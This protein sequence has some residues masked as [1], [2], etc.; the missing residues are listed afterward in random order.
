MKLFDAHTHLNIEEYDEAE[1]LDRLRTIEESGYMGIVIDAG[2]SPANSVQ[3]VRN[4]AERSWCYA[5]V[6]IH[7]HHASEVTDA[8][9]EMVRRLAVCNRLAGTVSSQSVPDPYDADDPARLGGKVVAIG[10]VGLDF[11]FEPYSEED[12]IRIFR[13]QIRI[14]NEL[15]L[16]LMIHT[17]DADRLTFDIL[18][19]EGA[20]SDERCSW[21]PQ[22]PIQ[23][24]GSDEVTNGRDARVQLHCYSGSAELAKEYL[25][26]GASFS[27]GGPITFKNSRKPV[28]VVQRIPL[29]CIMSETDAP[30][31]APEPL[32]GRP[33]RTEYIIHMV[34]RM[35]V[36]KNAGFEETAAMLYENGCRF[37]DINE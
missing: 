13:Q 25:R 33:N 29:S 22:R 8:D 16:P 37:F 32:R 15:R 20:F 28:Q 21:F 11:H 27:L 2:A 18:N 1:R 19:E 17:R 5:S 4:S 23:E 6:G 14:A 9:I 36:L 31:M 10:E 24:V 3:A 26:L 30:Y 34:R 7:P 12:Q 35:A